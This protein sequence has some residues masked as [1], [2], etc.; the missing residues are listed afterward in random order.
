MTRVIWTVP[1]QRD[2]R[3]LDLRSAERIRAAVRRYA[4]VGHGDVA[5]LQGPDEEYRLRVGDYRAIFQFESGRIV[6]IVPR[7]GHLRVAYR[8]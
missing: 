3:R 6:V 5:K 2:F 7:V 8:G 4:D 1:A